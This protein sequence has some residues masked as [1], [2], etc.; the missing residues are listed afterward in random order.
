M[1]HLGRCSSLAGISRERDHMK[2]FRRYL[3]LKYIQYLVLSSSNAISTLLG[4]LGSGYVM[5][6][7]H[8]S[9]VSSKS[10]AVFISSLARADLLIFVSAVAELFLWTSSVAVPRT[11][12]TPALLQNLLV[13]N[14]HISALLLSC[15]AMEAYLIT[16][17]PMESRSLRTVRNARLTSKAIWL[18]VAAECTL[19]QVDDVLTSSTSPSCGLTAWLLPL[20]SGAAALLRALSYLLGILLRIVNVYIYYKIFFSVSNRSSV[21]TK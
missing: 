13:A 9:R 6:I 20:S 16:F 8:S 12:F 4:V 7:L 19:L 11:A 14:T 21:R 3:V 10:T 17:F 15:V 18:L 2:D 1:P 5:L